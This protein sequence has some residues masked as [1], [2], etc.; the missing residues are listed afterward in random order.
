MPDFT[1]LREAVC[2]AN[3]ELQQKDLVIYSWGNVSGIDRDSGTVAIKPS[4]VSYDDL[5]PDKIVLVDLNGNVIDGDL[6]PSS[7]TAT[8]LVL[9]HKF[10]TIGGIC[11]THSLYATMWAQAGREIPCLGTTHADHF[12]GP[13]PVTEPLAR[14]DIESGYEEH[15][16]QYIVSRFND[17]DENMMPAA[18]VANH[19]PFTWGSNPAEA[20]SNSVILEQVAR[21]AL[22]T[23]LLDEEAK[24]ISEQLLDKHFLRKHGPQAYYGQKK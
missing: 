1:E 12:Y 23:V 9:Y 3:I 20:V 10:A 15:T 8:H 2:R 18:L 21:M 7:D 19:G 16:G 4:G 24:A 6:Q 11:H 5:T 17:L 22:G 14:A 13:I